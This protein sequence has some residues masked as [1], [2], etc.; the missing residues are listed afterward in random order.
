M[1]RRGKK[2]G[3]SIRQT[4]QFSVTRLFRLLRHPF[5]GILTILGNSYI[6]LSAVSFYWVEK[7]INPKVGRFFDALWWAVTTITTVGYGDIT[8]VSTAGRVVAMF[9]MIGGSALFWS[10]TAL[11]AAVIL[12]P[13]L[14][15]VEEEVRRF[16][17][18]NS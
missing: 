10:F 1:I 13:E 6:F 11:F 16:T 14:A 8:P 9:T 3:L 18:P 17:H 5:F 7:G 2:M 15:Q 12:E 4:Y